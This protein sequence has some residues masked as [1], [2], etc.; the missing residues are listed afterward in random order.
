M[1]EVLAAGLNPVDVV[2]D[3]LFAQPFVVAVNGRPG[4][5]RCTAMVGL[6]WC[7]EWGA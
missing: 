4:T 6:G 7:S 5:L 2:L 1:V 3:P